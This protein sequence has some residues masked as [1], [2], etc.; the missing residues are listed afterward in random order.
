MIVHCLFEQ[1]GTFKNEFKK[2]GIE[3]FDYDILNDVQGGEESQNFAFPIS[4]EFRHEKNAHEKRYNKNSK[5]FSPFIF[6]RNGKIER[7]EEERKMAQNSGY[8]I[9]PR[10]QSV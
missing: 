10:E 3:A 9:L 8:M 1:S 6:Y 2:F 4:F 7:I 5:S